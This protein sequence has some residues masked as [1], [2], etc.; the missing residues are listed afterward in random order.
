M[1]RY[2]FVFGT[3]RDGVCVRP[4]QKLAFSVCLCWYAARLLA[5]HSAR[6]RQQHWMRDSRK[7]KSLTDS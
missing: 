5:P 6:R 7:E 3:E 2:K 4:G 1:T